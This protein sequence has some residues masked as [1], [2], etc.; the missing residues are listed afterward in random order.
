MRYSR[1]LLPPIKVLR[2]HLAERYLAL[3]DIS[4]QGLDTGWGLVGSYQEIPQAGL[5][6]TSVAPL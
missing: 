4:T 5:E 2:R 3:V 6:D 1:Y